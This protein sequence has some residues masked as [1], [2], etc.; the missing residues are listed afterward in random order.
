MN[1]PHSSTLARLV[2]LVR[3]GRNPLARGVDRL[4]GALVALSVCAGLVLVP[5]M[6]T[7]GSLTYADLAEQGEEQVRTRHETVA[8]LTEDAPSVA[9]G[10]HGDLSV[11][12]SKVRAEWWLPDGTTRA[13]LVTAPDGR[14]AGAE[15]P[16]W[17]DEAGD[18]TD[19]PLSG[20]DAVAAGV[21]VAVTGWATATSLVVLVCCGFNWLIERHRQRAWQTEWARIEPQW[22]EQY[23]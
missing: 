22:R 21:L 7:I 23:R 11:G 1:T 3:P 14:H 8:T 17:L 9:F 20:P 15:V 13:G 10:A 2:R 6:L 5:V 19:P 18:P 16:V 4:Q 12:S